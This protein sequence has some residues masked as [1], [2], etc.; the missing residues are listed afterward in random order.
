MYIPKNMTNRL[1]EL[2]RKLDLAVLYGNDKI[3]N[4]LQYLIF[5]INEGIRNREEADERVN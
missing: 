3:T 2:E 1:E 5:N 4:H